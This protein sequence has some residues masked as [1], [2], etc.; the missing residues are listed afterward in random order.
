MILCFVKSQNKHF[1]ENKLNIHENIVN[2]V[3]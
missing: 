3:T 1:V 2:F